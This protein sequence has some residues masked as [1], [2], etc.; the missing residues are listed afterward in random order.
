MRRN[1][2]SSIIFCAAFLSFSSLLFAET[3]TQK[4]ILDNGMTVLITEIPSSPAVGLQAV[5][6]SGSATEGKYLGSGLSHFIEHML[7]KGTTKRGV[8]E[9]AGEVKSL[10]GIINAT[11]SFDY[12]SYTIELPFKS[13]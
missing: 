4:F 13:F 7:F 2:V 11:T 12:T 1:I 5:V 9:I 10:G 3:N 8:G 6:R